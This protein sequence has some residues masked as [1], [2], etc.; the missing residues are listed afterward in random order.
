MTSILKY[1]KEIPEIVIKQVST[2]NLLLTKEEKKAQ[3]KS[4]IDSDKF[5]KA[6]HITLY[7]L[8]ANFSKIKETILF[9]LSTAIDIDK[10]IKPATH[11]RVKLRIQQFI[12]LDTIT[13]TQTLIETVL[14]LIEALSRGYSSVPELMT[15]YDQSLPRKVIKKIRD[16]DYDLEKILSSCDVESFPITDEEKKHLK[17]LYDDTMEVFWEKLNKFADFFD[18]FYLVYLKTK[19]GL[20]IQSGG[21]F[22]EGKYDLEKS[23]LSILDR[24]NKDQMPRGTFFVKKHPEADFWYNAKSYVKF[25]AKLAEEITTISQELFGIIQYI[26]DS[27]FSYAT[28][29]GEGYLPYTIR[30]DGK[31]YP[32][33]LSKADSAEIKSD[34][35]DSLSKK[36]LAEMNTMDISIKLTDQFQGKPG[37]SFVNDSITNMWFED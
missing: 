33:F 18:R 7:M 16:K 20:S 10:F 23:Y 29:C 31:A 28:N 9:Y 15:K 1:P 13:K 3:C 4:F 14:V 25:N 24:K 36:I 32:M 5:G 35:E 12:F 19:H 11:P 6:T 21:V 17:L 2:N 37:E 34:L 30:E 26:V 22:T 8:A 27:S